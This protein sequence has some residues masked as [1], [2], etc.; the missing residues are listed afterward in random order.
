M[1]Y[2]QY[3]CFPI[4][5]CF[6]RGTGRSEANSTRRTI[7]NSILIR[8]SELDCII[9]I[10]AWSIVF[11]KMNKSVIRSLA[12][13]SIKLDRKAVNSF[14]MVHIRNMVQQRWR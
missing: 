3:Y 10:N 7:R 5:T 4:S 8:L 6:L 14:V 2:T 12:R 13:Q 11:D 9:E 1:H